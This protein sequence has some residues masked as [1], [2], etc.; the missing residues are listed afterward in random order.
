MVY[1]TL[2]N[3]Y[4]PSYAT[5]S[6]FSL[7]G[8][9]PVPYRRDSHGYDALT[10]GRFAPRSHHTM[11]SAYNRSCDRYGIRPCASDVIFN[12]PYVLPSGETYFR[13]NLNRY[14]VTTPKG[15]INVSTTGSFTDGS[16]EFCESS[17][18]GCCDAPHDT[19]AKTDYYGTNCDRGF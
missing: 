10:L 1:N 4:G 6:R 7:H 14:T 13:E 15:T 3:A 8:V 11:T 2:S 12:A 5:P 19:V 17:E 18:Y 9:Y 16:S